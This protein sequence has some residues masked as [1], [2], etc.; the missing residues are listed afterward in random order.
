MDTSTNFN[1]ENRFSA[2][3]F[4]LHLGVMITLYATAISFLNLLF[5]IINEVFPEVDRN[6]YYWGGGSEI[7]L[8]VATLIVAFPLF[9]ILGKLT[10]KTYLENPEKKNL[11]VRKWLIYITLFVTG[12]AFAGDLITVIYKFLDGQDLTIAFLLKALS[13]LLV[14]GSVFYFCL[15][16]VRNRISVRQQKVGSIIVTCV[17]VATIAWGFAVFGSPKTQRLIR[18]DAEKI[19]EL[20]NI[21]WQVINYW[22]INGLIPEMMPDLRE[23]FS[24][25]KTGDLNFELCATFNHSSF[26]AGRKGMMA[27]DRYMRGGMYDYGKHNDWSHNAGYYCF[28]LKIDPIAYPT[29]IRG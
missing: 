4:F 15:Q 16:D 14:S 21:E 28:D 20:Q 2:K 23:G 24:Y 18:K 1:Q 27:G 13:V 12:I 9:L 11:A 19:A 3:D 5:R 22:Q 25:R 29:Q 26:G 17:L 8:P 10:E 7:S 6:I